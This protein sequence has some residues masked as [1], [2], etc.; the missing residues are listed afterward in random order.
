V[1]SEQADVLA[2]EHITAVDALSVFGW[3]SRY[4][5]AKWIREWPDAFTW[6]QLW[7]LV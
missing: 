3:V 2:K 5:L 6:K 1:V 7:H 4:L